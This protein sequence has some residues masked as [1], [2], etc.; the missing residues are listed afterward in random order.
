ML[1]LRHRNIVDLKEIVTSSKGGPGA[2]SPPFAAGQSPVAV[3][4]QGVSALTRHGSVFMV[5]EYLDY[6]LGGL[7]ETPEMR[8]SSVHIKCYA[9]QLL[10]G[11]AYMHSN[12]ILHRDLKGALRE[13]GSLLLCVCARVRARA[14]VCFSFSLRPRSSRAHRAPPPSRSP[15]LE[16]PGLALGP[17]Q[18]RGLGAGSLV[19]ER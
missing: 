12:N 17:T 9:K 10:D 13:M 15:R 19:V 3:G 6:D 2:A 4:G 14:C 11:V 8:F 5:M 1:T 18:N 7:L 16:P